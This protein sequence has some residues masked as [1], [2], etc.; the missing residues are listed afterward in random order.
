[1]AIF[2]EKKVESLLVSV[3]SKKARN[4]VFFPYCITQQCGGELVMTLIMTD[5]DAQQ[6]TLDN[7][8]IVPPTPPTIKQNSPS[9]SSFFLSLKTTMTGYYGKLIIMKVNNCYCLCGLQKHACKK[10]LRKYILEINIFSPLTSLVS[11]NCKSK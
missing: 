11:L 1:M 3:L 4:S 6:T 8:I 7:V 9:S 5:N 10:T 2:F